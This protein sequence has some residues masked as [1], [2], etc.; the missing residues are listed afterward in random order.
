MC[1]HIDSCVIR[2]CYDVHFTNELEEGGT[3][4][5]SHAFSEHSEAYLPSVWMGT[6]VWVQTKAVFVGS[7][8]PRTDVT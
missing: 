2:R 7:S 6:G 1:I 3:F 5:V 4:R 8:L